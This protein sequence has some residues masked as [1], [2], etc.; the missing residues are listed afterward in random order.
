MEWKWE[1]PTEILG[2]ELHSL[3][4]TVEVRLWFLMMSSPHFRRLELL[5]HELRKIIF[6]L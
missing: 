2:N 3:Q 6:K 4:R 1:A 5:K